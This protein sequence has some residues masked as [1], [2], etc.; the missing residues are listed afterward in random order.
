MKISIQLRQFGK[1]GSQAKVYFRL[2]DGKKDMKV[3]SSLRILPEFW[4][5]INYRYKKATPTDIVSEEVQKDFNEKISLV[6][7]TLNEQYTE[8]KDF[9]WFATTVS[10]TESLVRPESTN[11]ESSKIVQKPSGRIDKT[12]LEYFQLYIDTSNFND[13]HYQSQVA[14]MRKVARFEAWLQMTGGNKDFKLYLPFFDKQGTQS[15]LD[16]IEQ[17]WELREKHPEHFA[18]FELYADYNIRPMSKNTLSCSAK[19][20]FMFL[21]WCVNNGYM[22]NKDYNNVTI[23]QQVYGTPFYLTIEERDKVLNYDFSFDARLDYH[24]DKFIFQCLV[25]CRHNDLATLTWNHIVEGG[26]IEYIPHKNLLHGKTDLVRCP[27]C[28]KA[29]EILERLDPTMPFL[30]VKY[31]EENYRRDIKKILKLAGIDRLVTILDPK[32]RQPVQKPIY[33]VA[34]SHLARRTFIGNLYKQV[35]DPALISSLTG[36]SEHS[37]SF[38]RYR[39]IDDNMK[40]D[41]LKFIQ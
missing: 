18:Q 36:H 30:F 38:E 31:C 7:R 25:G 5:S 27:L 32:S 8:G 13:W 24:R 11:Q 35:Q 28:D 40:R 14:V 29:K 33:E 1:Q 22:E 17:E 26:F 3:A 23:D 15:Y 12:M 41:I 9:L 4:D 16:Y 19:R 39:A 20:L 6:L 2:R 21:N 10:N 37:K 34:A